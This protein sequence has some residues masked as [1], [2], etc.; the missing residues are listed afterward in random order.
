VQAE[1]LFHAPFVVVAHGTEADPLLNYANARAGEVWEC[2]PEE[3]IGVPSRLTAEPAHREERAC[4]LARTAEAGYVDDYRGIR[5][6]RL[7]RRFCIERAVVWNV[8][9]DDGRPV[10]Q[11]ATFAEWFWLPE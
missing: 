5:I 1:R 2:T 9:D 7:G 8:V 11:A 3:L 10:G 4:L 6:S